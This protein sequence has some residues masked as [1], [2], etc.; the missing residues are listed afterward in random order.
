M[1]DSLRPH[2]LQ[3]ARTPCPSPTPGVPLPPPQP[4]SAEAEPPACQA[5][6]PVIKRSGTQRLLCPGALQGPRSLS[7][8]C[9]SMREKPGLLTG[10]GLALQGFSWNPTHSPSPTLKGLSFTLSG[11]H[12]HAARPTTNTVGPGV[13]P[14][15]HR[16]LQGP[17]MSS[18]GVWALRGKDQVSLVYCCIP[19]PQGLGYGCY[20]NIY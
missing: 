17:G 9:Q 4:L 8:R 14:Q 1:S 19:W 7:R 18:P 10:S 13:K 5:L 2:E 3:H 20:V 16:P 15:Q 6:H 11:M 12:T